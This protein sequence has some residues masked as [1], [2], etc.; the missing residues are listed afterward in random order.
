MAE[1]K[2]EYLTV[3]EA[4]SVLQITTFG[5]YSLLKRSVMPF[6]KFG[7]S[8]RIRAVDLAAYVESCRR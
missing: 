6:Y 4:A 2:R 1:T 3:N 7:A 8:I 5:M